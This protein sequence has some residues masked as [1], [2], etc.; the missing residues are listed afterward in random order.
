[1]VS[2][3]ERIDEALEYKKEV[4]KFDKYDQ[5]RRLDDYQRKC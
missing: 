3:A 5:N 2:I 1:M 4:N